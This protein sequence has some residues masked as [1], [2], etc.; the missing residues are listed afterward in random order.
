M[1]F[2]SRRRSYG[3]AN[4]IVADHWCPSPPP[5]RSPIGALAPELLARI[6]AG[7]DDMPP[8]CAGSFALV[9]RAWR[10]PAQE[11]KWRHL[12]LFPADAKYFAAMVDSPAC[13]RYRTQTVSVLGLGAMGGYEKQL[14]R[15]LRKLRG[16]RDVTLNECKRVDPALFAAP[17]F[18]SERFVFASQQLKLTSRVQ[19]S[20]ALHFSSAT[21]TR[22]PL[23]PSSSRSTS[24]ISSSRATF[25]HP[26]S[27]LSWHP[28]LPHSLLKWTPSAPQTPAWS[29]A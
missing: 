10:E 16:V 20:S 8:A 28:H 11:F 25:H 1:L 29:R 23:Q 9:C 13:G 7:D 17:T 19:T 6:F 4:Q 14:D 18:T 27:L 21:S 26:S 22:S 15:L 3:P 2:R 5:G 24:T 12:A